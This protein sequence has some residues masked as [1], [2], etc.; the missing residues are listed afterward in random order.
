MI[1]VEAALEIILSEI[2]PLGLERTSILSTLGRVLGE[3]ICASVDNPPW[4]NSAMDGYALRASDTKGASRGKPV[5]LRIIEDL[6]AGYVAKKTIKRGETVRIMTGAPIPRGADAVIMVEDTDKSEV[7]SQ[8]S[9]VKVFREAKIRDNIRRA[10]EDFKKGALVL[11]KGTAIRAAEVA[12]LATVGKPNVCVYQRPKVAV[13]ST[14]DELVE[15][16]ETPS[17]GKIVNSNSYAISAQIK[18]CGAVPVQLGIARDAKKDL[19]DKL[20][21]GL[22]SDCILSS[23]GVSVGDFDFVK[24]VLKEMGS[25]MRFWKVAIKPGK[26]LAFGIINNKPVF[27]LPGNPVSAMVAFEQFV[28]PAILKMMGVR[29]IFRKSL[30]ALLTSSLKKKAGR[31]HFIKAVLEEKKGQFY[32]TPL[33]GQ[34][35]GILSSMVM[36]NSL[37]ILPEDAEDA[38]KGSKVK[39]QPLDSG[40][41]YQDEP[42]Y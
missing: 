6:P 40:F 11:K 39:V 32:A 30:T 3:D 9:E 20:S 29:N 26:P 25:E 8:K 18:A 2:K 24:D 19:M 15:I 22:A 17:N 16:E 5:I 31:M 21:Y 37:I 41:L 34:G 28:R 4:D 33:E 27:G 23:G 13:L 7:R 38:A 12:M 36:A 14:G 35:S 42:G 1:S 10:G